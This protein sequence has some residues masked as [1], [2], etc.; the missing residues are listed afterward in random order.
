MRH[1]LANHQPIEQVANGGQVL[2]DRG[3]RQR[4]RLQFH[5]GRHVQ[6]LHGG[7]RRH[8][9][10]RALGE[11]LAYGVRISTRVF[12][13]RMLDAKNSR[14]RMPARSP[15]ATTSVGVWMPLDATSGFMAASPY[16]SQSGGR[17]P[18]VP[19]QETASSHCLR[20]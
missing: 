8:T 3:C 15:A 9:R 10:L 13:L 1:D 2:L 18:Q 17:P 14:E 12:G 20:P 6:R 5:P 19:A 7:N 4:L 11:K 16:S